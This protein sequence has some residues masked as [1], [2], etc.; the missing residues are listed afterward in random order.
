[1]PI[2]CRPPLG[3]SDR[4]VS[5][6]LEVDLLHQPFLPLLEGSGV[7][8]FPSGASLQRRGQRRHPGRRT[9][10]LA[11]L[12]LLGAEWWFASAKAMRTVCCSCL[13]IERSR[14]L[15]R[16]ATPPAEGRELGSA[17]MLVT[18]KKQLTTQTCLSLVEVKV[19]KVVKW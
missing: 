16:I 5:T 11:V 13:S 9:P 10:A 14:C 6:D 12:G 2:H 17:I 19:V 7:H 15:R 18:Q 1:M 4:L 8:C 3:V